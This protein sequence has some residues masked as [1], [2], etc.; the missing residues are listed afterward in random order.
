MTRYSNDDPY[1]DPQTGVLRNLLGCT[2]Q[3]SFDRAEGDLVT[4]RLL[5][6]AQKPLKDGFDIPHLQAIHRQLFGDVYDWAGQFRTVGISR[7]ASTFCV[8]AYIE[9]YAVDLFKRLTQERHLVDLPLPRFTERAAFFLGELNAIH[10]FRE[11]NGRTQREFIR[12]LAAKASF[13]IS[14]LAI[15]RQQ[16]IEASI[17]SYNGD[18]C[19]MIDLLAANTTPTDQK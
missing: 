16:M 3:E 17:A 5:E 9:S 10:P 15:S 18:L 4:V 6:I 12:Q 14:W 19:P 8:P 7:G 11:G 1:L 13:E 2:S